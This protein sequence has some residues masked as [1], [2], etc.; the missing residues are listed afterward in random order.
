MQRCVS[1]G[2]DSEVETEQN[3]NIHPIRTFLMPAADPILEAHRYFFALLP[4]AV[5]A[6]RIHAFAEQVL[7]EAGLHPAARLHVT[8]AITADFPVPQP[9]K[10]EALQRAGAH[11][12]VGPF[13]LRLDHLSG[14]QHTI[15]LRSARA[16]RP[17]RVLQQQLARAMAAEGVAMRPGFEFSPHLTLTYRGGSPTQRPVEDHGW[18]AEEFVLIE[19]LVGLG[20]YEMHGR[21]PL[22]AALE[23][24]GNLFPD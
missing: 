16:I 9:L 19:S 14:G 1:A 12:A 21:W 18:I 7:G 17:L 8:L 3:G 20:R 15:A 5:N 6:N 24:Q 22:R 4:D 10:L 2:L 23:R 11:A 13:A